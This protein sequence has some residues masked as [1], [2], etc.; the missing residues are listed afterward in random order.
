[1]DSHCVALI[2]QL[3]YN[4]SIYFTPD[5]VNLEGR[6][7]MSTQALCTPT[8]VNVAVPALLAFSQYNWFTVGSVGHSQKQGIYTTV[9]LVQDGINA[10]RHV[11]TFN[12]DFWRDY[13]T[14]D[15]LISAAGE[16]GLRDNSSFYPPHGMFCPD[17]VFGCM[18]QCSKTYACTLREENDHKECLVVVAFSFR[19][20]YGFWPSL[21]ANL[22]IPAYFCYIGRD[23]VEGFVLDRLHNQQGVLFYMNDPDEFLARY[24]GEFQRIS[25]PKADPEELNKNTWQFGENGYG[26]PNDNPIRVEFMEDV[27]QKVSSISVQYDAANAPAMTLLSR[28]RV[29]D[30][31]ESELLQRYVAVTNDSNSD[32]LADPY[33][34]P[35][36]SWARDNYDHWSRWMDPMPL[37][38][39]AEH[40]DYGISGCN[41]TYRE[42]SFQWKLP[43]PANDSAPYEC[44]G[45]MMTLPELMTTSRS[46]QWLEDHVVEWVDWTAEQPTC[47]FTFYTYEAEACNADGK[48]AIGFTWLLPDA[49]NV[50]KSM[51]CTGG[52]QL[53]ATT[54]VDCEYMPTKSSAFIAISAL[55][56]ALA[57][58]ILVSMVVVFLKRDIPI[59]RRS[60]FEFLETMLVGAFCTC[61]AALAY[62]GEPNDALCAARP[63]LLSVG[64]TLIFGSLVMKSLRV[65]RVFMSKKLKR[66]VLPTSTMFKILGS[67][68]LVDTLVLAV[69]FAADFPR[70]EDTEYRADTVFF[71][72][73]LSAKRC[74]SSS[75]IY[76][77]LLIFWKTILLCAG[78]YLS[79]LVR[80][81]SL[82]FQESIWIFGSAAVV[83]FGCVL[84][85][86]L[87]YMVTVAATTFY[88][89]LSITLWLCTLL[90]VAMMLGP[91]L[92]RHKEAASYASAASET[93]NGAPGS[94]T[95]TQTNVN[96]HAKLAT[97]EVSASRARAG[98]RPSVDRAYVVQPAQGAIQE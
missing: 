45:G 17:H 14:N 49:S 40:V 93:R 77:A 59:V 25:F 90:I 80:N 54:F 34:D 95:T 8:N 63:A 46:C 42:I 18:D 36:C 44:D 52:E 30:L 4:V 33:F 55:A 15:E 86:P 24:R 43:D 70:A 9:D 72:A 73:K 26:Q 62:A 20:T 76:S 39:L 98:S 92:V 81:V 22:G 47:D 13:T 65:Y 6:M 31:H 97:S 56:V 78:L 68:L 60:Q 64:F 57:C 37:C 28:F 2:V 91:K 27:L 83:G 75:F 89:F 84:L 5:F 61:A 87:A 67:C 1:M 85:L 19:S 3:G 82:D 71:G 74:A 23:G 41:A 79:F 53:P 88:I 38:S 10:S 48:R 11:P 51:E 66:V 96:A 12:A 21:F 58:V 32:P 94:S 50:S 35:A 16:S 29:V 7:T 69:W